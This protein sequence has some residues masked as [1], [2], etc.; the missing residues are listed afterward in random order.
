MKVP[1]S[2][3]CKSFPCKGVE[4]SAYRV[5]EVEVD[6]ARVRIIMISE[7]APQRPGDYF[8]S[9]G[10]PLYAKTTVQAFRDVGLR[11]EGI[12][13]LVGMGFYFT[14]AVKC[15]KK[16]YGVEGSIVKECSK[17][18]E[19]ELELFPSISAVMLMGDV[20]IKAFNEIARRKTGS[21]AIPAG[22]TYKIRGTPHSFQGVRVFPSYLQ[23]G[24]SFFIEK[25]KRRMI[26]QDIAEAL[27]LLEAT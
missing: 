1:E 21:R 9:Q 13:E 18:L 20:A 22:P 8:Y 24:P 19:G 25:N 23:A 6:P 10:E 15:G 2:I 26:A 5:P 14:T 4:K 11:V 3:G 16:G 12:G 17:I 27:T 7:S